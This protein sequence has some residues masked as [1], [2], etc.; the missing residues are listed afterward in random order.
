M[1]KE[2]ILIVGALALLTASC[3]KVQ[4]PHVAIKCKAKFDLCMVK[5]TLEGP[6][7]AHRICMRKRSSQCR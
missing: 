3:S 2:I 5:H 7:N 4:P 6:I 1:K